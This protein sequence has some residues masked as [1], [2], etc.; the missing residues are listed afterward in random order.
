MNFDTKISILLKFTCWSHFAERVKNAGKSKES[1]L[2][3]Q[4]A[5]FLESYRK[6]QQ[7]NK[8]KNISSLLIFE[9]FKFMQVSKF[10]WI[11]ESKLPQ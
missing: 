11:L 3:Y 10:F 8:F 6:I 1:V 7:A 5:K 9:N 4:N 2:T